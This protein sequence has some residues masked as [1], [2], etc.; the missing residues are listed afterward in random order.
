MGPD[1]VMAWAGIVGTQIIGP[2]FFDANVN[3]DTYL[4]MIVDNILPTLNR[5]DMDSQDV[6]CQ[7]DGAPPHI[8]REVRQCLDEN[9]R[10]WIGR[11][12]G[13]NKILAW[14]PRSP[15][16]NML[17]FFLWGVLQHRVFQGE[18]ASIES[19]MEAII[20]ESNNITE[21]TLERVQ[22]HL[23]KR[24]H[25]CIEQNGGIFEHLLK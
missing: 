16:L 15:D 13:R 11:G 18:H 3:R 7:H 1:K 9:F 24:L 21:D 5:R 22:R 8:P 25:K 14:P 6:C 10:S 23:I 19:I 20:E 12:E 4:Q 17:D 2:F